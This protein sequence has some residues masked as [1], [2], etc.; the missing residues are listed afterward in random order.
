MK[1]T[2][3]L[4]SDSLLP[5]IF[6]KLGIVNTAVHFKSLNIPKLQDIN[7]F[8]LVVFMY[9]YYHNLLL[10]LFDDFLCLNA[11]LQI[12]ICIILDVLMHL[13]CQLLEPSLEN[14]L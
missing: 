7:N 9:K 13:T 8:Q 2:L 1:I 5:R 6:S 10:L 12:Y 14:D 3:F 11:K 4:K